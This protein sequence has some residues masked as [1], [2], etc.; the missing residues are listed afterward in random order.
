MINMSTMTLAELDDIRA[1][2]RRLVKRRAALSGVVAATPL[3]MLDAAA[4]LGILMR[5]LP[6][7]SAEF[8]LTPK[9]IEALDPESRAVVYTTVKKLGDSFV[10]RVVTQ[11]AVMAVL[12]RL[13][14]KV[15]G[16]QVARFTPII[17]QATAASI[18]F[19]LMRHLGN[20]HIEDCYAVARARAEQRMFGKGA[21]IIEAERLVG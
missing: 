12:S 14:A 17:G 20:K 9:D 8:D 6:K 1:Q 21:V 13:G 10:G 15:A 18:S 5:M 11:R 7:I 2:C 19:W 3:P 16:K 4:D